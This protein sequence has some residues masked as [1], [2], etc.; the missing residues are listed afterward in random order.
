LNILRQVSTA[1]LVGSI[2]A[3]LAAAVGA[4]VLA[5]AA[6]GS[7]GTPSAKPL[8]Q[9]LKDATVSA[10]TVGVTARVQFTNTLLPSDTLSGVTGSKNSALLSSGA[11]RLWWSTDGRGRIELQSDAGDTQILWD[12]KGVTVYDSS[13]NT[14]Y[15]LPVDI[16]TPS[17]DHSGVPLAEIDSFLKH[18]AEHWTLSD[19]VPSDVAGQPAY[20]VTA[21]PAHPA[22]L[23]G[24]LQLAWDANQGVPLEIAITA[25]GQSSPV[26]ALT[27]TDI[28]YG[29]VSE[30]DLSI[31]PPADAKTVELGAPSDQ[32][33]ST[34]QHVSGLPAVQAAL[35]FTV[36][37][38]D[39]LAGLQ[40][41]SV[42]LVGQKSALVLY[43]E[44]L[45]GIAV[46]E[47]AATTDS[48][49]QLASLP[50]V[51][52]GSA[53]GHELA[54][55]LGAAVFF[56]QGGVSYVVAA[57]QPASTVETAARGLS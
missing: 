11:G 43:G 10:G 13:S 9:A 57:S 39:T 15:K 3:I 17:S 33:G 22:G 2:A 56:D 47:R 40:R 55:A 26:L 34:S 25:K 28:S 35:P 32:G 23:L 14:V 29:S 53:T 19:A 45:N 46:L 31:S 41:T 51:T 50:S 8:D 52:I 49:S 48:G 1:R 7:G 20:T 18:V 44:G 6:V 24:S 30:S 42:Q 12:T 38:P 37:A 5:M 16:P 36:S 27:V 21:S 54:T 4:S